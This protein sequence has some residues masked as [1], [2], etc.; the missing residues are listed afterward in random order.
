MLTRAQAITH[1]GDVEDDRPG[2]PQKIAVNRPFRTLNKL[3]V[4]EHI[5]SVSMPK[6][7]TGAGGLDWHEVRGMMDSQLG[8]LLI[9]LF[10]YV[11][12]LDGQV[13]SEPGT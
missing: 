7:G 13:A 11:L 3:V 12:E 5:K 1:E 6:I 2:R 9:P 10:I 4:D 8:E